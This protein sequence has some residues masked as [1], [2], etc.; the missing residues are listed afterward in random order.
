MRAFQTQLHFAVFATIGLLSA[1]SK[2][3]RQ[4]DMKVCIADGEKRAAQ[5]QLNLPPSASS[6]DR[7]DRIGAEV[8]ECMEAKGYRHDDGAM[9]DERCV[10][11][12]DYNSFC[13]AA[14]T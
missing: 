12:V 14:K 7:H 3:H 9:T 6:E 13:Y 8:A 11:D 2:D 5:G 10:N 4:A 1:C